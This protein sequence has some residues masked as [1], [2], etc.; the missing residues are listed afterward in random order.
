MFPDGRHDAMPSLDPTLA[1][2]APTMAA[3]V[4]TEDDP[5]DALLRELAQRLRARGWRV[6]GLVQ[7]PRAPGQGPKQMA[8]IDLDDARNRYSISQPLGPS[9]CG[10]CNLDPAGVAA[11]SAVLRRVLAEGA[12]LAIAN[13]FGTLESTGGGLA[14]EMLALMAAPIPL[15]T[16][17]KP[18]YLDAWRAFTGGLAAELPPRPDALEA[19]CATLP[20][21]G[22][23]A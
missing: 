19:W 7:A 1:T 20:R 22:T 10:S 18:P 11:A 21:A 3:I 9:A 14:G 6:R 8:L 16:V 4:H 17:V 13:R 5:A 15:L 12:D 23:Q 2:S